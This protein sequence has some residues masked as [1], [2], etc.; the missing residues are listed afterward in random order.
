MLKVSFGI[1][2]AISLAGCMS[3]AT[4]PQSAALL[5]T[6]AA[7]CDNPN[8]KTIDDLPMRCGAQVAKPY[9]YQSQ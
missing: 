1:I 9:T 6:H 8:L 4:S 7:T 5:D 2:L 3:G